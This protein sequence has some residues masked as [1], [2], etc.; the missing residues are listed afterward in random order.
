[1]KPVT[2][3]I[4]KLQ[5]W[6]TGGRSA[7]EAVKEP[8]GAIKRDDVAKTDVAKILHELTHMWGSLWNKP[9]LQSWEAFRHRYHRYFTS[10]ARNLPD[11]AG[12]MLAGY[13]KTC[14]FGSVSC[15][16]KGAGDATQDHKMTSQCSCP[17]SCR[18][19]PGCMA[20]VAG[21]TSFQ[22]PVS[23]L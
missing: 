17:Q 9:R 7:F 10:R 13:L 2:L 5:W 22:C 8:I 18:Y 3:T 11:L 12:A 23:I 20:S 4:V 16:P 6:P 14:P 21:G 19:L 1:M 15:L